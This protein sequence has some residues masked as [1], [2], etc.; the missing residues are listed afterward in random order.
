MVV[1]Q[2]SCEQGT[3]VDKLAAHR[4]V[5]AN[6]ALQRPALARRHIY[7][8]LRVEWHEAKAIWDTP[9]VAHY[10]VPSGT[11]F[12]LGHPQSVSGGGVWRVRGPSAG[13]LWSPALHCQLIGVPVAVLGKTEFAE[14]VE[15]WRDWLAET[16]VEIDGLVV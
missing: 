14:P 12:E 8:R 13:E 4:W 10:P 3:H 1:G 2:L 5:L 6:R 16:M 9:H 15:L 7:D 11:V